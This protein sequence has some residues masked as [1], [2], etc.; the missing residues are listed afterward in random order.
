MLFLNK[1]LKYPQILIFKGVLE[2]IIFVTTKEQL[3]LN[4]SSGIQMGK[5]KHLQLVENF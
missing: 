1:L 4:F 3:Y 5:A 2:P